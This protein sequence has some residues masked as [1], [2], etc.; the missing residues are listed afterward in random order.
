ARELHLDVGALARRR[1]RNVLVAVPGEQRDRV[2]R[3]LRQRER[4]EKLQV[5]GAALCALG[6]E[7]AGMGPGSLGEDQRQGRGR[8]FVEKAHAPIARAKAFC[9]DGVFAFLVFVTI[10]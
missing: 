2:L 9:D 10:R 3:W 1:S 6:V 5:R 7:L 4:D 8:W